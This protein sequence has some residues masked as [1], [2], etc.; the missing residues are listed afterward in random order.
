VD[1]EVRSLLE[2]I[3]GRLDHMEQYL[4]RISKRNGPDYTPTPGFVPASQEVVNLARAG[5]ADAAIARYQELTGAD[6]N[7]ARAVVDGV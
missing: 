7:R 4:V 3:S 6:V 2:A 1:E 5:D